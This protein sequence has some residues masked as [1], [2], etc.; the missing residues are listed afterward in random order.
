MK[1][2]FSLLLIINVCFT[3]AQVT[4]SLN[5]AKN[6]GYMKPE[7]REM[8]Y[9]INR[10]RTNPKSYLSYIEPMLAAA[11]K[12]LQRNGKGSKNYSVTYTGSTNGMGLPPKTDTVWHYINVEEVKALT[13]LVNDLNKLKKLSL[14]KPDSGI[15]NATRYYGVD[16]D[17]HNWALLHQGSDG[18]YPWDRI[19]RFSPSMKD[20]NENIAGQ[21]PVAS[22]RDVLIQLLVDEGIPGYGHRYNILNPRWTH[23]ACYAGGYHKGMF[24]W[25]QNF[26]EHR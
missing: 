12:R 13:T 17:K 2:I 25:L 11:K 3:K 23:I 24:R 14:L 15:Y 6:C 20:G 4:D 8:I 16:Q 26:G 1:L 5:T 22:P 10:L 18:S 7:E 9:E 19:T 21:Y